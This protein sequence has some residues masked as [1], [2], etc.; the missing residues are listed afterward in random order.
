M[1]ESTTKKEDVFTLSKKN[2]RSFFNE[3]EKTSPE[4]NQSLTKLQQ[5]YIYAWKILINSA[6]SLEQEYVT[7]SG[8]MID[9]PESVLQT[10]HDLTEASIQAYLQQNKLT[11]NS[12]EA[13]KQIFSIF[14]ENTQ[15]FTRL[16]EEIMGYL[17]SVFE[18][19]SKT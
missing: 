3:I 8:F 2:I 16:N 5:N 15:S 17:M 13:S 6:I 14:N 11:I 19:K 9:V 10:I 1:K 4:I 12:A 7:K 18:Q